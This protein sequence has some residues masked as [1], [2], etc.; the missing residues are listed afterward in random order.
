MCVLDTWPLLPTD[1]LHFSIPTQ[2][3]VKLISNTL[4]LI[5][6]RMLH[7]HGS[8]FK[9]PSLHSGSALWNIPAFR[10]LELY[11]ITVPLGIQLQEIHDFVLPKGR[12]TTLLRMFVHVYYRPGRSW[13]C[14]TS[15]FMFYALFAL[16]H[17]MTK[18]SLHLLVVV[19]FRFLFKKTIKT[20][21]RELQGDALLI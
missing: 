15:P 3:K 18:Y 2:S 10:L 7:N 14:L 9:G 21:S 1:T 8:S 20:P 5:I 17:E 19:F 16:R 6:I 11:N 13:L 4:S 12:T